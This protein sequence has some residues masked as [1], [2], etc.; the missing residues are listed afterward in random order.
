MHNKSTIGSRRQTHEKIKLQNGLGFMHKRK[1]QAILCTKRYKEHTE[2]EKYYHA[3][4]L[5]YFPWVDEDM[6]LRG[7]ESYQEAY[8]A[9]CEIGAANAKRFNDDCDTFDLVPDDIDENTMLSVW[10]IAAPSISQD[11]AA[12]Q[13]SGYK[14]LQKIDNEE[15]RP[16]SKWINLIKHKIHF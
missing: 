2:T 10:D 6:I 7:H 15:L 14:T 11:D 13:S 16:L 9:K 5:L 12:T 3:K 8:D 4:L 1:R